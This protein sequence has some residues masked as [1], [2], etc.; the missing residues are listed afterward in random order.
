MRVEFHRTGERRYAVVIWRDGETK[1]EMNPAPG[2]DPLMPH[3]LLHFLV[4]QELGLKKAIFGHVAAG[5]SAGSFTKY[6]SETQN[7][8][9]E[10][11]ERRKVKQKGEKLQKKDG[12]DEYFQSERATFFCWQNWLA[13]S[14]DPQLRA[15]AEEMQAT[16][17]SVF[18][19]MTNKEKEIF[20]EKKLA[21]IRKRMDE[22]SRHWSSLKINQSM[23]LEW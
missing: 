2:F 5:G 6:P 15:R 22:L 10:A 13:N 23:S 17:Q 11:R 12:M 20:T 7:S 4:E 14:A 18:G 21:Q 3:D 16:A 19:T 1:L 8:R 9:K